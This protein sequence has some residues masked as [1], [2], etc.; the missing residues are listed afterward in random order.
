MT[1]LTVAEG[2]D[3]RK[4]NFLHKSCRSAWRTCCKKKKKFKE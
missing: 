4:L 2:K 3:S 1:V